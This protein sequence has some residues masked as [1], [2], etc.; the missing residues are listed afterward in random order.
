MD[1]SPVPGQARSGALLDG[2]LSA[3]RAQGDDLGEVVVVDDSP[4]GS[5]EPLAGVQVAHSEGAGPYAARNIGARR[6]GAR[7]WVRTGAA[8]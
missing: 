6:T 2:C 7:V 3:L 5:L 8:G 1:V 4:D